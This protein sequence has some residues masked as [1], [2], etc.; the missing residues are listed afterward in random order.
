[1]AEPVTT[2]FAPVAFTATVAS[3][4][5]GT[6]GQS[7]A[8]IVNWR[9]MADCACTPPPAVSSAFQVICTTGVVVVAMVVHF[10]IL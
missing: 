3:I 9:V 6:L 1:M 2:N 4:G 10:L 7:L 8:D 5:G